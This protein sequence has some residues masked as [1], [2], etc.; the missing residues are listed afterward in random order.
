MDPFNNNLTAK[1]KNLQKFAK[2]FLLW[3]KTYGAGMHVRETIQFDLFIWN[4][5]QKCHSLKIL[6]IWGE[7][8][9]SEYKS[10]ALRI[11]TIFWLISWNP[12][13][14]VEYRRHLYPPWVLQN[15]NGVFSWLV[16]K[17]ILN[18]HRLALPAPVPQ[19]LTL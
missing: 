17:I 19:S 18:Q 13:Y 1:R 12:L 9:P 2:D 11:M 16:I 5:K 3:S 14:S 7:M 8:R 10:Q 15:L 4:E 6:P